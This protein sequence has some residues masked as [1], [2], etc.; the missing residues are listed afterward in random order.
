MAS[1]KRREKAL[2]PVHPHPP[3]I[4]SVHARLF[5]ADVQALRR[6]AA[7]SGIPWHVEL[8]LL[9]HRALLAAPDPAPVV[10]PSILSE[11]P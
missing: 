7:T 5:A 9:V 11:N 10:P 6:R 1:R 4:L 8:R 2:P 3:S